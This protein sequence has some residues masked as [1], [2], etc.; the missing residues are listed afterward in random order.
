M[1]WFARKRYGWGLRP[2][3]WQGWL[4]TLVYVAVVVTLGLTL[5]QRQTW[6]F[7]TTLAVVSAV[8][9]LVAYLTKN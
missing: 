3:S 4:L 7:L 1:A 9:L 2:S 5:A 6:L 8:Y